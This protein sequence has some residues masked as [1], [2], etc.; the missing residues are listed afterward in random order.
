M[1]PIKRKGNSTESAPAAQPQKRVRVGADER[2]SKKQNT[3]N[4]SDD[5]KS[6]SNSAPKASEVSVL[7]DDEPSFPR[8]GASVLTPLERKEIQNQA[9]KDVLFEQKGP[10]KPSGD[11]GDDDEEGG[12]VEMGNAGEPTTTVK[13]SRKKR[14]KAKK[15]ADHDTTDEKQSVRI[16]GLSFNVFC[17]SY[18][19]PLG[20]RVLTC[21]ALRSRLY[22][23]RTGFQH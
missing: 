17:P 2:K 12:D 21:T 20:D 11:L 14:S 22:G 19:I 9:T 13:K 8:G 16:E 3:N 6:A 7:R 10:K 5:S 1:A 15:Q 23:P 18:S 4:A